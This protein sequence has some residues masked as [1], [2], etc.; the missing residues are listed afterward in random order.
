MTF[1]LDGQIVEPRHL[2]Q[3]LE[4]LEATES[5]CAIIELV[6]VDPITNSFWF[7]TIVDMSW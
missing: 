5:T 1:Y 2:A 4:N 7:E 3:A 6:A